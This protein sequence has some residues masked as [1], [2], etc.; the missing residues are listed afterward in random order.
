MLKIILKRLKPQSENIIAEEQ[1]GFRHGGSTIEH[2][3]NLRIMFEKHLEHR[4]NI[5]HVF[6]DFKKAFDR[7]WHETV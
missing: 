6:V 1:A 7:M 4:R 5:Y 2:I 3:F